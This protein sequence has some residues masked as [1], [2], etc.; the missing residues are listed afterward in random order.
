M[1]KNNDLI[2]LAAI[3]LGAFLLLRQKG[4][5]SGGVDLFSGA[6]KAISGGAAA[7]GSLASVAGSTLGVA[8]TA[9]QTIATVGGQISQ[10]IGKIGQVFEVLPAIAPQISGV[11]PLSSLRAPR[12][13]GGFLKLGG[14]TGIIDIPA[15]IITSAPK[16]VS[17]L[18]SV[19]PFVLSA[20]S[21][22][23]TA[24]VVLPTVIKAAK[25]TGS[26][27]KTGLSKLKGLF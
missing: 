7:A 13:A 2:I 20:V 15:G 6:G 4:L 9:G 26:F 18:K 8:G 19:S 24:K 16:I 22:F 5:I 14:G 12:A 1:V 21:P 11:E 25:K 17:R 27:L 10:D 23:P 3:G